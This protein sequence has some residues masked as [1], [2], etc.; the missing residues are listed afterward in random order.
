MSDRRLGTLASLLGVTLLVYAMFGV[1]VLYSGNLEYE[2]L[3]WN[4]F[5][6]WIPFGLALAVY[7]GFRRGAAS[8]T[9][10][11]MRTYVVA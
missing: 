9:H 8:Q 5:L 2:A 6:A 3:I 1:R 11:L 4:L 7:D 10:V